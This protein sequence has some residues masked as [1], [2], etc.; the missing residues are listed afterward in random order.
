[1]LPYIQSTSTAAALWHSHVY[2]YGFLGKRDQHLP[3]CFPFSGLNKCSTFFQTKQMKYPQTLISHEEIQDTEK[4]GINTKRTWYYHE[5]KYQMENYL[6]IL[7]QETITG[8]IWKLW[9]VIPERWRKSTFSIFS[10]SPLKSMDITS[11]TMDTSWMATVYSHRKS[12][13]FRDIVDKIGICFKMQV[14]SYSQ[15]K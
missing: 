4:L 3:L 9:Q 7:C 11:W 1:M 15:N 5:I 13:D 8:L 12:S 10:S 14:L 2:C 6:V